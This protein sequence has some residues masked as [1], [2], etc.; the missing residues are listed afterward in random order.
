MANPFWKWRKGGRLVAS[1]VM[2]F[3]GR[4]NYSAPP[5][6]GTCSYG[7]ATALFGSVDR[8]RCRFEGLGLKLAIA[9]QQDLDFAFGLL[10]FLA[11][12][13]G[14]FHALVKELQ[15]VVERYVTLLQ[16]GNNLFQPLEALFKLG[17]YPTPEAI[18][19]QIGRAGRENLESHFG[20]SRLVP[21]CGLSVA[22]DQ[23]LSYEH[24]LRRDAIST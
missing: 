21:L 19:V 7:R 9:L 22:P 11:A 1:P 24:G 5:R 12:G 16:F 13:T 10:Q 17:Q 2:M 8:L 15:R 23:E 4:L 14:K 20:L 6:C 3:D 18:L